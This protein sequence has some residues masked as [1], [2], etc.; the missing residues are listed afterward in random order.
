MD[1][2]IQIELPEISLAQDQ[3]QQLNDAAMGIIDKTP[4]LD[5]YV[6]AHSMLRRALNLQ[7][8]QAETWSNL[9]VMPLAS[10]T[11]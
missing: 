7:P 6:T 5:A 3:A 4:T 10:R 2:E 9:G 1:E 8:H 11:H